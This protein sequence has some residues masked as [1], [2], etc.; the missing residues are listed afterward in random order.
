MNT[1]RPQAGF[2]LV[3][4]MVALIVLAVGMLG[5]ASLYVTTL[6]SSGSAISRLQAVNLASDMADRI[7]ANR[8][9]RE[10][11]VLAGAENDCVVSADCTREQM[12]AND[13]F[14]WKGQVASILPGNA[15]GEIGFVKGVP[16]AE[17]DEGEEAEEG[18]EGEEP[19]PE[20][21]DTYVIT[22]SW[23]EPGEANRLSYVL[24]M[25]VDP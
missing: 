5:I 9:A 3:E 23:K 12:A 21:L 8:F 22:V 25:Q 11:Y 7:R 1:H 14:V 24:T 16:A 20:V 13:V 2:N 18:E 6:R 19:A 17:D 15:L 4:V 10:Q